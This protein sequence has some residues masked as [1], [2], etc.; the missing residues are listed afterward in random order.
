MNKFCGALS[1][2]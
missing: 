2:R 1:T